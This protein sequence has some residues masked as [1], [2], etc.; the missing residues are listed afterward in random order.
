MI[1]ILLN[2]FLLDYLQ[3]E[4][5]KLQDSYLEAT[6]VVSF[7][8]LGRYKQEDYELQAS[9][10]TSQKSQISYKAGPVAHVNPH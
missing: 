9:Y 10:I 8:S 3:S 5:R 1:H 4:N 6:W 2:L 7:L